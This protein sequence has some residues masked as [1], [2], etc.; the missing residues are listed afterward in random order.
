ML[1]KQLMQ[2][3]AMTQNNKIKHEHQKKNA[4]ELMMKLLGGGKI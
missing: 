4:E 2:T 1:M 3:K